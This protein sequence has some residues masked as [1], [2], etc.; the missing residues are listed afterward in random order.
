MTAQ[1]IE[2]IAG[3]YHGDAFRILGLHSV[4]KKGENGR[5]GKSERSCLTPKQPK[6]R[7]RRV[8]RSL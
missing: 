2:A 3:G 1:E 7:L 6:F 4:R 8:V 5:G